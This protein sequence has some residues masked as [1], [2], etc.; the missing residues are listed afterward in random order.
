PATV[1]APRI[2][3]VEPPSRLGSR[4]G[5]ATALIVRLRS[6]LPRLVAAE[7]PTKVATIA[8]AC[9]HL[10]AGLIARELRQ[11]APVRRTSHGLDHRDTD[12]VVAGDREELVVHQLETFVLVAPAR[13]PEKGEHFRRSCG[14]RGSRDAADTEVP[15]ERRSP[16]RRASDRFRRAPAARAPTP[17]TPRRARSSSRREPGCSESSWPRLWQTRRRPDAAQQHAATTNCGAPG[18]DRERRSGQGRPE[19]TSSYRVVAPT[20]GCRW[21]AP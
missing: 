1:V 7:I 11:P 3:I 13:R 9:S 20:S 10:R 15:A 17:R 6:T 21:W 8:F 16:R 5:R 12:A 14:G 18:G 19:R 2:R 4:P